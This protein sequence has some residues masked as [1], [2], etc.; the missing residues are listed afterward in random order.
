MEDEM[1]EIEAWK[2]C[3]VYAE[4]YEVSDMGKVRN[5]H[6]RQLIKPMT[7]HKGY[8]RVRLSLKDVK[9]SARV[10]RLVA[11]AFM[12]NPLNLAQVNHIDGNKNNNHASNL[13]WIS[14][15]E[16]MRHAVRNNLYRHV[17]NA[18]RPKRPVMAQNIRTNEVINF[19]SI[20]EAARVTG[21]Y[22]PNIAKVCRHQR[23]HCGG[24]VWKY[25]EGV[26]TNAQRDIV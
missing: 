9:K 10:H 25:S 1:T 26:V 22:G 20:A 8:L 16:N 17:E 15:A 23:N 13:E 4:N 7:D 19:A 24:Y 5:R 6:T 3:P 14:N 18:G 21:L 2:D 11:S 12:L